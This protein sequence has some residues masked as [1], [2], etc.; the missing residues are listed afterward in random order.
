MTEFLGELVLAGSPLPPEVVEFAKQIE[1]A[2]APVRSVVT[3][4]LSSWWTLGA[5][6]TLNVVS[7][8]VL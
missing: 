3:P 5:W 2:L 8:G 1:H 6:A 7:L 4:V